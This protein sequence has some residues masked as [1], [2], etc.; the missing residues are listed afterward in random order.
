MNANLL[1]Q[2]LKEIINGKE[3]HYMESSIILNHNDESTM[4]YIKINTL[5]FHSDNMDEK[6]I[7]LREQISNNTE[8]E[9]LRYLESRTTERF[10]S[11]NLDGI[12]FHTEMD[13]NGGFLT[14]RRTDH[15]LAIIYFNAGMY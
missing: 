10:D 7:S 2:E 8:K 6:E 1:T 12:L 14:A 13:D 5:P 11:L 3:F 15:G 9:I 4:T